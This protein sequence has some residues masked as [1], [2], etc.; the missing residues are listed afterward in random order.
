MGDDSSTDNLCWSDRNNGTCLAGK[1]EATPSVY[2]LF[3]FGQ[4]LLGMGAAPMFTIGLTYVDE[5]TQPKM[6]SMYTGSL[7]MLLVRISGDGGREGEGE[8]L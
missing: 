3:L 2:P 5:N 7:Q 8:L 1:E 6:V 4:I